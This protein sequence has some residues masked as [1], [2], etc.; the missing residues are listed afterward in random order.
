MVRLVILVL[1]FGGLLLR[2]LAIISIIFATMV[3]AYTLALVAVVM[4]LD[5]MCG[6]YGLAS[7]IN[8]S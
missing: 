4:T 5:F 1:V 7:I 6:V 8:F 2:L 3:I